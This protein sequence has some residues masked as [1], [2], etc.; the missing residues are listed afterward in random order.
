MRRLIPAGSFVLSLL[1][2]VST[3]GDAQLSG[4]RR[5]AGTYVYAGVGET[6]TLPWDFRAELALRPDGRYV[7]GI[8]VQV[9]DEFE[10]EADS[11]EYRI[12]GNR[13]LLY[14]RTGRR[15]PQELRIQGDS[16]VVDLD[17]P[18]AAMLLRVAGVPR[19]VFVKRR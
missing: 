5:I 8:E 16:L 1:A 14:G 2:V 10:E 6:L 18:G 13:V 3:R 12:E 17:E 4:S 19:P 7:L 11:G 15:D 9:K